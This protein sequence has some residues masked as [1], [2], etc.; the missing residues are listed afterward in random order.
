M[1]E[2]RM[3]RDIA[4]GPQQRSKCGVCGMSDEEIDDT[5][6]QGCLEPP[7]GQAAPTT[8]AA[9]FSAD[10]ADITRQ[11]NPIVLARE[12]TV[13]AP[14]AASGFFVLIDDKGNI[15]WNMAGEQQMGILWG[16]TRAIHVLMNHAA[17]GRD[18]SQ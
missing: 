12:M 9:A 3:V 4:E 14:R 11:E 16:L 17:R 7:Q 15:H 8:E 2:H 1:P 5:R 6:S 10:V 18:G 13:L